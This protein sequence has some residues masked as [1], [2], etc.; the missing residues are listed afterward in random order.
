MRNR[1][2]Y[3]KWAFIPVIIFAIAIFLST[4]Q[5]VPLEVSFG[6]AVLALF[7]IVSLDLLLLL[8]L[9]TRLIYEGY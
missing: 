3:K 5:W 1:C 6:G 8:F 9:P 4:M 7:I 2:W